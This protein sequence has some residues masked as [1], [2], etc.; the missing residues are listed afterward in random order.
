MRGDFEE[1][2][3][4]RG[5]DEEDSSEYQQ[6]T[7]PSIL[8]LGHEWIWQLNVFFRFLFILHLFLLHLPLLPLLTVNSL[9]VRPIAVLFPS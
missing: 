3:V 1:Y 8:G 9:I 4:K 7:V 6:S 2:R 5:R